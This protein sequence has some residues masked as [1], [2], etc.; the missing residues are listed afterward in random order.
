MNL[1][2]VYLKAHLKHIKHFFHHRGTLKV[3]NFVFEV[4]YNMFTYI[5]GKKKKNFS[6]NILY[7]I[8]YITL[9]LTRV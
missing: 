2:M 9:F 7:I 8:Q 1:H 6:H 4:S 5:Q 3:P